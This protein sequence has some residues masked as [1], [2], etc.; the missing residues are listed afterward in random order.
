MSLFTLTSRT[1][2][3]P[4][5]LCFFTVWTDRRKSGLNCLTKR[6]TDKWV[7]V[8]DINIVY[9]V[10]NT[11]EL[12]YNNMKGHFVS[13]NPW[14]K[15]LIYLWRII[16]NTGNLTVWARC[17]TTRRRYNRVRM[18]IIIIYTGWHKKTRTFENPTKLKHF[19]GEST[20]LT[21]PLINDY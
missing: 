6:Q 4:Q 15:I 3:S 21:V 2:S 5:E 20:L 1:N 17:R 10:L 8:N 19:Y 16:V 13:L 11:D 18:Y 14:S 7:T 9:F 12:S